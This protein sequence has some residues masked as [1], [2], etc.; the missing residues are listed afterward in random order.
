MFSLL[1]SLRNEEVENTS[2]LAMWSHVIS[3][4]GWDGYLRSGEVGNLL[5]GTRGE[6]HTSLNRMLK[7]LWAWEKQSQGRQ[8]LYRPGWELLSLARTPFKIKI[9]FPFVR[10]TWGTAATLWTEVVRSFQRF[11]PQFLN[12]CRGGGGVSLGLRVSQPGGR[13]FQRPE[14][15]QKSRCSWENSSNSMPR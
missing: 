2:S 6:K 9:A 12:H 14:S 3:G 13:E 4:Q 7:M 10:R 15:L 1:P 8:C 5:P 11:Q